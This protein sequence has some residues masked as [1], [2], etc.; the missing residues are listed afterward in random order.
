VL[1]VYFYNTSLIAV[2]II[3]I[4]VWIEN[5]K[6]TCSILIENCQ[7]SQFKEYTV[8]YPEYQLFEDWFFKT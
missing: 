2:F 1:A 4:L 5:E 6:D 3:N 8:M 7:S